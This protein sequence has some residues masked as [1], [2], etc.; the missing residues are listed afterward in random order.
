MPNI[1]PTSS[2]L[3]FDAITD[4]IDLQPL[5]ETSAEPPEAIAAADAEAYLAAVDAFNSFYQEFVGSPIEVRKRHRRSFHWPYAL[6]KTA[7]AGASGLAATLVVGY[8][9]SKDATAP[10]NYTYQPPA[11]QQSQAE[12]SEAAIAAR[13]T[14]ELAPVESAPQRPQPVRS[15]SVVTV[16]QTEVAPPQSLA[17]APLRVDPAASA[18]IAPA[19]PPSAAT[20][21]AASVTAQT[22]DRPLSQSPAVA[23]PSAPLEAAPLPS[24]IRAGVA[25]PET[26]DAPQSSGAAQPPPPTFDSSAAP[27]ASDAVTGSDRA[28]PNVL[29]FDRSVAF[30]GYGVTAP[31]PSPPQSSAIDRRLPKPSAA[32]RGI[33]DFLSLTK[34][35]TV[36]AL[37]LSE[38]AADE[39]VQAE[40][41]SAFRVVRLPRSHYQGVWSSVQ[42]SVPSS[43]ALPA[44][45]RGFID[46]QQRL[47]VLPVD[48]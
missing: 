47:I 31:Q 44:P 14:P 43:A 41:I 15:L 37:P 25:P 39:A 30:Q 22:S 21:P 1:A 19:V 36:R 3:P 28:A 6:T 45:N 26:P 5:N 13:P 46:A 12:A 35:G 29:E 32:D 8:A 4:E 40:I 42:P 18:A 34:S 24:F 17:V 9:L 7:L 2:R 20:A 23:V 11:S 48:A 16:P 10:A 27:A 38:R 33:A